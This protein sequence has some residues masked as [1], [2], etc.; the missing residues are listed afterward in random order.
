MT[1]LAS[2]IALAAAALAAIVFLDTFWLGLLATAVAMGAAYEYL[3][4]IGAH[5]LIGLLA[6]I[7]CA[8]VAGRAFDGQALAF[9]LLLAGASVSV[10]VLAGESIQSAAASMYGLI[11]IGVPLGLLVLIHRLGGSETVLL[12]IA[13]VVVSDSAQYSTGRSIGRRPLAPAISPKK[14]I[15]GAAGGLL[16]ATVFFVLVSRAVLPF[17]RTW[18]LVGAG[19]AVVIA[20]IAGDLF[21]SRL[22]RTAGLKDSSHLIPGH[23]GILDRIDALLFAT[24]VFYL[25]LHEVM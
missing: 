22:K 2:G 20:G 6:G 12:L 24:P 11:Y 3:R 1:R 19:A 9:V 15:E 14:T 25:F 18:T 4:V 13:T 16:V 17:V 23:G 7:V 8:A 21:E 10:A 5:P